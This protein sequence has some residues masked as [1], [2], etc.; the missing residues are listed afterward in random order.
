MVWSTGRRIRPLGGK[1][2]WAATAEVE[3]PFPGIS[4]DFGLR[5]AVFADAGNLWDVDVP[6]GGGPV[7][8]SE[9]HPL[10]GRWLG[11]VGVAGRRPSG[12]HGLRADEGEDR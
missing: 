5:G 2:Y 1:N 4:P 12:G 10:V 9:H 11:L 8:G 3:F 6:A 7:V